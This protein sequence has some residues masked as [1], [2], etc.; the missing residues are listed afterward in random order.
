MSEVIITYNQG[1][2]SGWTLP[3]NAFDGDENIYASIILSNFASNTN[4][5]AIG[6]DNV[7]TQGDISSVEMGITAYRSGG[8]PTIFYFQDGY[9][10][11]STETSSITK[12]AD[13]TSEKD[14]WTWN[15]INSYNISSWCWAPFIGTTYFY[16]SRFMLRVN[17]EP[18][19]ESGYSNKINGVIATKINGIPVQQ[20]QNII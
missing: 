1:Q 15:D 18:S 14:P 5:E 6:N 19:S 10:F 17:Y 11:F 7:L 4:L 13:I 20:I 8:F 12:W 9:L 16:A 3:G 2:G